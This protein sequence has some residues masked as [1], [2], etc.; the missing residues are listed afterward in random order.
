MDE[1]G[2]SKWDRFTFYKEEMFTKTHTPFSPWITVKAND[3][4][5]GRLESIRYLLSQFNYD[6]KE[7]AKVSLHPDPNIVNRYYRSMQTNR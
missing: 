1:S 2:R 4:K 3:K 6:G 7:N 5:V